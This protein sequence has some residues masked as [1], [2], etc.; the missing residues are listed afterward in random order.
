MKKNTVLI[1]IL[2]LLNL[3]VYSQK[4][5]NR[6]NKHGQR[7]GKW[8]TYN[9]SA[10]LSK[11][12]EGRYRNGNSKGTFY[13]YTLGGILE[14]KEVTRFKI[15]KTS[16]Y[17]ADG[18]V[19]F[20]GKARIDNEIDKIHYYFFGK[21]TYYDTTGQIL[22]YVYYEKGKQVKT[23]YKD[24]T[25]KTNDSLTNALVWLDTT[26][27]THNAQLLD[28]I[29]MAGFNVKKRE[30]L[31]GELYMTDTTSYHTLEVLLARYG[32]PS[33]N[34]VHEQSVVPFYILS[35]A[36]GGIRERYLPLLVKAADKGDIEWKS[37]AYYIDKL[38]V[39]KGEKQ[40]YGTQYYLGPKF[41]Q[42]Y[43]PVEDPDKL[44]VRRAAVGL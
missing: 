25:N 3:Q 20:K 28:S 34:Q 22:K 18:K 24:K 41:K 31:Q 36:P 8:I 13:F 43:Y 38:K 11:S 27:Q 9:D 42:I 5:I 6:Y 23:V 44:A 29:S 2:A 32:Y 30:R 1:F 17:Y 7:T 10:K 12:I 37:L 33:K 35:F 21:W 15:L 16:L 19:Q 26:F 40:V 4:K 39:A 14:R